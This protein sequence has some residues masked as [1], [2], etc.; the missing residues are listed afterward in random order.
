MPVVYTTAEFYTRFKSV[1]NTGRFQADVRES[2]ISIIRTKQQRIS[3]TLRIR[4]D[5]YRWLYIYIC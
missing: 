3:P 4:D 1:L 2:K 5:K